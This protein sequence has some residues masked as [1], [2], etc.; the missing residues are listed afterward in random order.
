MS[1]FSYVVESAYDNFSAALD[2]IYY[3]NG[4]NLAKSLPSCIVP[5]R[6]QV[7]LD[8]DNPIHQKHLLVDQAS[9]I[10]GVVDEVFAGISLPRSNIVFLYATTDNPNSL[11]SKQFAMKG[12]NGTYNIF[13]LRTKEDNKAF[14]ARCDVLKDSPLICRAN[15]YI[16]KTIG[17]GTSTKLVAGTATKENNIGR[18]S[19]ALSL[20]RIIEREKLSHLYVPQ[21][22]VARL[23]GSMESF[24]ALQTFYSESS[25]TELS[26]V[27]VA[28]NLDLTSDT[29]TR[30]IFASMTDEEQTEFLNELY[31]LM[32][33]SGYADGH[34][35]NFAFIK[36]GENRGK[37]AI[38]DTEPLHI[39][40]YRHP[41]IMRREG[42]QGTNL[43]L[44]RKAQQMCIMGDARNE[45]LRLADFAMKE[46]C[47][48]VKGLPLKD[49]VKTRVSTKFYIKNRLERT[50]NWIKGTIIGFSPVIVAC[51]AVAIKQLLP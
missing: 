31:T 26:H 24:K 40:S 47:D 30:E 9:E 4:S 42:L 34:R 38:Y 10:Q 45:D 15:D 5:T 23:P 17:G 36:S 48:L 49:S 32:N 43:E 11:P 28:E 50:V 3:T 6:S 14:K 21:K 19:M 29:E 16:F 8:F 37:L 44:M 20:R 2:F 35:W 22:I 39:F 25:A 12:Q 27:V 18:A 13:R 41:T 7:Y 33:L 1:L 51:V 46:S